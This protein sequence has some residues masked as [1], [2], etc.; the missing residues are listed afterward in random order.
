VDFDN[1]RKKVFSEEDANFVSIKER[2][3]GGIL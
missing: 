3:G 2:I 1:L